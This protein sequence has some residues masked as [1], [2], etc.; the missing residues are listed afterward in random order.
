MLN[1][2]TLALLVRVGACTAFLLIMAFHVL[3]SYAPENRYQQLTF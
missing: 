1:D 3:L 2:A